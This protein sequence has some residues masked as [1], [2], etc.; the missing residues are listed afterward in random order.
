MVAVAWPKIRKFY[1]LLELEFLLSK[2]SANLLKFQWS[3]SEV[4]LTVWVSI[5]YWDTGNDVILSKM[6]PKPVE[7][8]IPCVSAATCMS[9]PRYI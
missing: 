8:S 1:S 9:N 4:E 2:N 7:I 5:C 3:A 6:N